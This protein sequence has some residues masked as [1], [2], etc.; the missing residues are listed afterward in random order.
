LRADELF[1][2]AWA[3]SILSDACTASRDAMAAD[4]RSNAWRI[5]DAHYSN[6]AGDANHDGLVN[7][8]D[9][10]VLLANWGVCPN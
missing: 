4:G 1:E 8:I 3:L 6:G 10:S 2:R 7:A 9:V 5:F